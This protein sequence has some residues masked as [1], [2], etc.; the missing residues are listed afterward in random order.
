[1]NDVALGMLVVSV[2]VFTSAVLFWEQIYAAYSTRKDER[3]AWN[4]RDGLNN[5]RKRKV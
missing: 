3:D 2:L 1:M 5:E 4:K